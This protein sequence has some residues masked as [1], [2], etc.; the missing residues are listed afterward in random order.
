[1]HRGDCRKYQAIIC[2][3]HV[4]AFFKVTGYSRAVR[5]V[6][7][8]VYLSSLTKNLWY[9]EREQLD[10]GGGGALSQVQGMTEAFTD[11]LY[12]LAKQAFQFTKK[13]YLPLFSSETADKLPGIMLSKKA[14]VMPCTL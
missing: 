2:N 10:S 14:S 13:P 7:G 9:K 4:H 11:T 1:M 12:S 3:R 5:N 8:N 6:L